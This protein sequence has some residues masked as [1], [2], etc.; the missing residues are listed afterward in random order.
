MR[1]HPNEMSRAELIEKAQAVAECANQLAD[2]ISC[3][4]ECPSPSVIDGICKLQEL[5]GCLLTDSAAKETRAS[6][7]GS[8]LPELALPAA[9]LATT[10]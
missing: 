4:A 8:L 9:A 10:V 1:D 2:S 7:P 3:P 5:V 6:E